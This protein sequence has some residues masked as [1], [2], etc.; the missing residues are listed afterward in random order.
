MKDFFCSSCQ[1]FKKIELKTAT[2][3]CK[4]CSEKIDKLREDRYKPAADKVYTESK[5]SHIAR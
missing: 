3:K 5:I 1:R 2:G 4:T